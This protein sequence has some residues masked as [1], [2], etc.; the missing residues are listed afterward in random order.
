MPEKGLQQ[1]ENNENIF[2]AT[3]N[4]LDLRWYNLQREAIRTPAAET[5]P[6][7]IHAPACN[8]ETQDSGV[9]SKTTIG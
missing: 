4:L 5:R 3:S 6:H 1:G 2:S 7:G 9:V 8:G